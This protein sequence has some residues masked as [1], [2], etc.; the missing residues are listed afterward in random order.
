MKDI[1]FF[2][3]L[4]FACKK[5]NVRETLSWYSILHHKPLWLATNDG[6]RISV[7]YEFTCNFSIWIGKDYRI[8]YIDWCVKNINKTHNGCPEKKIRLCNNTFLAKAL[9]GKFRVIPEMSLAATQV[10]VD[11]R[12]HIKI[13]KNYAR[14]TKEKALRKINGDHLEQFNLAHTYSKELMKVQPRSRCY[15]DY[16]KPERPIDPCV[17]RRL[18]VCLKPLVDGFH[19]G[20]SKVIGL[21]GCYT[22]VLYK[23]QLLTAVGLDSSNGYWPIAQVVVE[24]ESYDSWKWVLE[25]LKED[26]RIIHQKEYVFIFDKQKGLEKVMG[27]F[28]PNVSKRNY[29]QHIYMNMKKENRGGS[30]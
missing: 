28:V 3:G 23:Q 22:K 12:F 9:E 21:D 16:T 11:D 19:D 4:V 27:K 20:C 25:G 26:L 7:K 24:K 18:Y 17:F 10:F 8:E 15:V 13:S 2:P 5:K 29:A 6:K 14:N 1:K 30:T